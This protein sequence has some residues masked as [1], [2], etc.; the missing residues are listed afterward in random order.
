MKREDDRRE[1]SV[2]TNEISTSKP[3]RKSEWE[4]QRERERGETGLL[5]GRIREKERRSTIHRCYCCSSSLVSIRDPL[6]P[7]TNTDSIMM[8]KWVLFFF[9]LLMISR[10]ITLIREPMVISSSCNSIRGT[11]TRSKTLCSSHS[12]L[13]W[14]LIYSFA[15]IELIDLLL[16]P[17]SDDV[18]WW[19]H[20]FVSLLSSHFCWP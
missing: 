6:H 3:R 15:S 18:Y 19:F 10:E 5:S 14:R 12:F 7:F 17:W 1:R 16:I 4:T 11:W 8:I 2:R 9:D 13:I 20:E